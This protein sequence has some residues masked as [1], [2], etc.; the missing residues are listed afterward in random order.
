MFSRCKTVLIT[1]ALVLAMIDTSGTGV[2]AQI[3]A[4]SAHKS[5]AFAYLQPFSQTPIRWDPCQ[6]I[7][8]KL[9]KNKS[10]RSQLANIS[11]A[12]KRIGQAAGLEFRYAGGFKDYYAYG[13]SFNQEITSTDFPEAERSVLVKFVSPNNM[14][15]QVNKYTIGVGGVQTLLGD[16]DRYPVNG[17]ITLSTDLLKTNSNYRQAVYMHE[18]A[19]VVG[20]D[21]VNDKR[22]LMFAGSTGWKFTKNF[23]RG[24]LTGLRLLG[25]SQGC[26]YL[27]D[28]PGPPK[29]IAKVIGKQLVI[30]K[31]V[32]KHKAKIRGVWYHVDGKDWVD[33]TDSYWDGKPIKIP[34]RII[35]WNPNC[36]TQDTTIEMVVKSRWGKSSSKSST[37][38]KKTCQD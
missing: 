35:S 36:L 26:L 22:S 1:I 20:L 28:V 14:N 30:T 34:L 8:F 2:Q 33:E 15:G 5:Y 24:D 29:P 4:K 10:G 7:S 16:A 38:V 21:H 27:K 37:L 23:T 13:N 19:H 17:L 12:F 9:L 25:R 6:K 11:T 32:S 31:V 18:I 3:E